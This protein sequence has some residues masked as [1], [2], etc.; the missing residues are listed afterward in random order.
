MKKKNLLKKLLAVALIATVSMTGL[1]AC[2]GPTASAGNVQPSVT[3]PGQTLEVSRY[4]TTF[5]QEANT[6]DIELNATVYPLTLNPVLSW[7]IES[8]TGGVFDNGISITDVAEL[9]PDGSSAVVKVKRAFLGG[10]ITVKCETTDLYN[11][12]AGTT[13]IEYQGLPTSL[14]LSINGNEGNLVSP[15][16]LDPTMYQVDILQSNFFNVIGDS[17]TIKNYEGFYCGI[18]AKGTARVTSTIK[19][20]NKTSTKTFTVSSDNPDGSFNEDFQ[21]GFDFEHENDGTFT[22]SEYGNVPNWGG[23][24]VDWYA[25]SAS[26]TDNLALVEFIPFIKDVNNFSININEL[27]QVIEFDGGTQTLTFDF[28]ETN[29]EFW[30]QLMID[31]FVSVS[32]S[33]Y[34]KVIPTATGLDIAGG[35]VV[36]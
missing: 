21:Y 4:S 23:F 33:I 20:G 3:I 10:T 12:V 18:F 2:S 9:I 35:N 36:I 26:Q 24:Y 32:D 34:F 1:F 25:S 13:K 17:T 5:N 22:D 27:S 11:N 16:N 19:I 30:T 14:A 31:G 29:F 8:A 28:S 7:S 15:L 6:I